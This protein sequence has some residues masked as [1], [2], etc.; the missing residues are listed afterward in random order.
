M[1]IWQRDCYLRL[2]QVNEWCW[3]IGQETKEDEACR[4]GS[5]HHLSR[6]LNVITLFDLI[7]SRTSDVRNWMKVFMTWRTE[8]EKINNVW[9]LRKKKKEK[10]CERTQVCP[11]WVDGRRLLASPQVDAFTTS[12]HF[13]FTEPLYIKISAWDQFILPPS[14]FSKH[15]HITRINKNTSHN[16]SNFIKPNTS[17]LRQDERVLESYLFAR[18]QP[19]LVAT[20]CPVYDLIR[21]F[22][23]SC[24][25]WVSALHNPILTC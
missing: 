15:Q 8:G 16:N 20:S 23:G 3:R 17:S 6:T 22:V 12:V 21:N 13:M 11:G 1:N 7:S 9:R 14:Q 25:L 19:E 5:Q 24:R 4:R 18:L 10:Y 2:N